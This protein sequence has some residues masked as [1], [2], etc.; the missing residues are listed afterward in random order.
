MK[1]RGME[2]GKYANGKGRRREDKGETEG[3]KK[4]EE[5]RG[6]R[7]LRGKK[8]KG[9]ERKK[10]RE[11]KEIKPRSFKKNYIGLRWSWIHNSKWP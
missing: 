2:K 11:G 3:M 9:K 6:E 8:R 7:A 5:G 10:R 1:E 4:R